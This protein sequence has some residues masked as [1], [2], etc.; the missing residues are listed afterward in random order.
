MDSYVLAAGV[1]H[2][3]QVEDLGPAGRHLQHLLVADLGDLPRAGHDPR[4]GGEHAVHVAVD[5]AVVGA[6]RGRQRHGGGVRRSAAEGGDVLGVLSHALE[7]GDDHDVAL[8]ER[9]GD[10][11]RRDVDDPGVAVG[12]GGDDAGL[13]AGQRAGVHA[14]VVDGHGQQRRAHPLAGR[15]QHV[16]FARRRQGGDP[17]G[18]L[19][20]LVGGVAHG[21]D[22]HDH[23]VPELLGG[24]DPLRH[25]LDALR[26]C[27][28]RATVLLHYA[29]H[30]A[31]S[32]TCRTP[33]PL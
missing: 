10:P 29:A 1:L 24:H 14:L 13:R 33:Q 32:F 18:Q 21:G 30:A 31:S 28:R 12:P 11:A 7:A 23:V 26:V 20:Q 4:V 16:Q 2:A 27:D 9:T 15:E 25:P 3:P 5:L 22:D 19:H 17:Q 8:V 6:Q